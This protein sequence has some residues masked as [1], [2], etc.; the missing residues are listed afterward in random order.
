MRAAWTFTR[1]TGLLL[2]LSL[3][4]LEGSLAGARPIKRGGSKRTISLVDPSSSAAGSQFGLYLT[5]MAGY[6]SNYKLLPPRLAEQPESAEVE[7]SAVL[8]VEGG[9]EYVYRKRGAVTLRAELGG[10]ARMPVADSGLAEL[11]AELP[12][13]LFVRLS[14]RSELFLSSL[15][16][17]ERSR[18]P[19]VFLPEDLALATPGQPIVYDSVHEALRPAVAYY[20]ATWAQ[21]EVGAYF[22]VKTVTF[23][24]SQQE[25]GEDEELSDYW[26]YDIGVDMGIKVWAGTRFSARLRYDLASRA[27]PGESNLPARKPDFLPVGPGVKISML[28]QLVGLY[29]NA[30]IHGPVRARA[31]YAVRLVQDNGGYY[32]CLD[33]LAA[34]GLTAS[35]PDLLELSMG[36]SL[37]LRDY[38]SRDELG[39]SSSTPTTAGERARQIQQEYTLVGH[40]RGE[41]TVASWLQLVLFYEMEVAAADVVDTTQNH[42]VLAGVTFFY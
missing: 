41:W 21:L 16:G 10:L 31:S 12:A 36:I 11:V 7:G 27:F 18:T 40:I 30:Q 3:I 39:Y 35:L 9:V 8:A 29:L 37:L 22:R 23:Y 6:E 26:F 5:P 33:H 15:L 42:R 13:Q 24:A 25:A 34:A 14:A 28:R 19:P 38:G 4:A 32:E 1:S 17:F 20:P 2:A